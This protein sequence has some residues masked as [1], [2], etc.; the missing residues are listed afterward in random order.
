MRQ[1][2]CQV[3]IPAGASGLIFA[4]QSA[5]DAKNDH[6]DTR[7]HKIL[8]ENLFAA[9]GLVHASVVWQIIRNR[10]ITV[11]QVAGPKWRVHHFHRRQMTAL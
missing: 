6:V 9:L 5:R 10:L 3:P 4:K 11:Q 1:C 8:E 2:G 7:I